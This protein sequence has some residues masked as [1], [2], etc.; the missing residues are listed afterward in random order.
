MSDDFGSWSC[1]NSSPHSFK[2]ITKPKV[3][4]IKSQYS[5]MSIMYNNEGW[6]RDFFYMLK[7]K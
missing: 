6:K 4:G 7:K 5:P 1:I 3:R 2:T